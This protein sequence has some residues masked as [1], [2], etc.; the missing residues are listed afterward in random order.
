[1]IKIN[2]ILSLRRQETDNAIS[3]YIPTGI[4]GDYQKN[5]IL[6]KNACQTALKGLNNETKNAEEIMAPAFE[7]ANDSK[8]WAYQTNGLAAFIDKKTFKIYHLSRAVPEFVHLHNHF[9]LNPLLEEVSKNIRLFV[10]AISQQKVEFFEAVEDGI[11][12]VFIDDIVVQNMQEAL[13]IDE[14]NHSLQFRSIGGGKSFFHGS[15]IEDNT[16]DD[17]LKEYFRRIDKGIMQIIHD[18][19]VPMV[20]AAVKEYHPIYKSITK[21]QHFSNHII[22][23]NP[24][25]LSTKEI[26]T[27]LQP[28][29]DEL[30][31]KDKEIFRH[32][33][34]EKERAGLATNNLEEILFMARNKNI[35]TLAISLFYRNKMWKENPEKL[36][37]LLFL[38]HDQAAKIIIDNNNEE[39]VKALLRFNMQTHS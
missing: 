32:S 1:M 29:F 22:P 12:P 30:I 15:G 20:L 5:R 7:L 33:Y 21:Y 24:T 26:R 10:L 17:H 35:D 4:T 9:Y 13:N 25:G 11:Y 14:Y 36:E 38:I 39:D 19:K 31:E 18:E 28:V 37:E 23:G 3:I 27:N 8:F 16:S 6:W 34:Q 2:E